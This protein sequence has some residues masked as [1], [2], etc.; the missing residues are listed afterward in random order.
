MRV[1]GKIKLGADK[2][3][4]ILMRNYYRYRIKSNYL[5]R[6][7]YPLNGCVLVKWMGWCG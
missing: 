5:L 6:K 4:K 2:K 7:G 1:R 3:I